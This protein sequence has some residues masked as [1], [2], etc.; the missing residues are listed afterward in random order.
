MQC[1][2]F[3]RDADDQGGRHQDLECIST[4]SQV[5]FTLLSLISFSS[6]RSD[7]SFTAKQN[8][9]HQHKK[10]FEIIAIMSVIDLINEHIQLNIYILYNFNQ[11]TYALYHK[12][13]H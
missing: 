5:T 4:V 9:L 10:K 2:Y 12:I 3:Y 8:S 1:T 6:L 11:P 13:I 7:I